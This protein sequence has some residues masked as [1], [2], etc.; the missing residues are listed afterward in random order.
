MRSSNLINKP[1][2]QWVKVML[3][4][5]LS[6][7]SLHTRKYNERENRAIYYVNLSMISL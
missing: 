1:L 7:L 2:Q 6:A 5:L 3:L 4:E